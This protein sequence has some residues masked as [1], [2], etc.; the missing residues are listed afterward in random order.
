MDFVPDVERAI[1]APFV[2]PQGGNPLHPQGIYGVAAYPCYE[3][4]LIGFRDSPMEAIDFLHRRMARTPSLRLSGPQIRE[5][6]WAVHEEMKGLEAQQGEKLLGVLVLADPRGSDSPFHYCEEATRHDLG[7]SRAFPGKF[8]RPRFERILDLFWEA[9]IYEGAG[10]GTREGRCSVC[11]DEGHLITAY[12]KAWPWYLPE[13]NCPLPEGGNRKLMVET[14]ALCPRCYRALTCGACL[15]KRFT[16]RVQTLVT[17][18]IFSPVA[19][20]EGRNTVA[21]RKISDLPAIQGSGFLLPL[22]DSEFE[23]PDIRRE[24]ARN[25]RKMLRPPPREGS[26]LERYLDA[27]VGFDLFLPEGADAENFRVSLLY[28]SGDP[29]RGD[30]HLQAYIEDVVP[31]TLHRLKDLGE[32]CADSAVGLLRVLFPRSSEAR[33]AFYERTYRSLPYLL[34]RAYGGVYIWEQ[35]QAVLHRRSLSTSRPLQN[36]AGR[37]R[38]VTRRYPE[39]FSE[40]REEVIFYLTF[41]EFLRQYRHRL[42]NEGG[43]VMAMRPWQEL[44]HFV[45]D[46]P[47]QELCFE[48]PAELGFACGA[49]MRQ[50]SRQYYMASKGKDYLKQRVIAFGSDLT[51]ETVWKGLIQIFEVAVRYVTLRLSGDFRQRVGIVLAEYD[52]LRQETGRSKDAFMASFW[53][54]YS[55]QGYNRPREQADEDESTNTEGEET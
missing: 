24:F 25:V 20:R 52:R 7:P 1:G 14:I 3:K 45:F 15:F 22:L 27:V 32:E 23:D 12:S 33:V 48:S 51:P 49:L 13:W 21:R 18:E 28:F 31:S 9:K 55:L 37:L 10:K 34:A 53:S 19:D 17:R 8:I 40:I 36:V 5:V 38:S 6:A 2:L 35:V 4:H 11:S 44:L 30:I 41:I 16:R 39:R 42:L 54:G 43:N 47:I 50:F 29:G 46:T 26:A